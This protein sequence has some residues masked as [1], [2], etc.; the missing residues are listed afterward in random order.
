MKIDY[1]EITKFTTPVRPAHK[2]NEIWEIKIDGRIYWCERPL[3]KWSKLDQSMYLETHKKEGKLLFGKEIDVFFDQNGR[4]WYEKELTSKYLLN[5]FTNN[6]IK[7]I[8]I[9]SR[10]HANMKKIISTMN[11]VHQSI[12]S[13]DVSI[14][15]SNLTK[16]KQC[17]DMFYD[18][19]GSVFMLFDDIVY[20]FRDVLHSFLEKK[21]ANSYFCE[22]LQAEI[23]KEALKLGYAEEFNSKSRS[24]T[25]GKTE[26]VVF[27]KNPIFIY[28][29]EK[30]LEVFAKAASLPDDEFFALRLIMPIGMQINEEAQYVES[31]ILTA[32]FRV[33]INNVAKVLKIKDVEN[34]EYNEI[35]SRLSR[36]KPDLTLFA[37][38]LAIT[39]G[40]MDL[41]T[42]EPMTHCIFHPLYTK[43]WLK[44]IDELMDKSKNIPFQEL[45]KAFNGLSNLRAEITFLFLDL[46]AAKLDKEERLRY[47]NYFHE[48]IKNKAK[49]DTYGFKSNIMHSKQEIDEILSRKF[50]K[51]DAKQAPLLGKLYSA[52][53][54]LTNGLYTDFY[55]D[56]SLE[57]FGPYKIGRDRIL[58][59]KHFA[60][61]R[62]RLLWPE[63]KS[64]CKSFT[65]YQVFEGIKYRCDA[66]SCHG[67]YEGDPVKA[68]KQFRVEVNWKEVNTKEVSQLYEQLSTLSS[69]QWKVM[70][71]L[72]FEELKQ[73]GLEIRCYTMKDLFDFVGIDWKPSAEMKEA[74]K[75]KEWALDFWKPPKEEQYEYWK[76]VLDPTVE[77]F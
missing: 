4:E 64:P 57:S 35:I 3:Y 25:Y 22:F 12:Y 47:A 6:P 15:L 60:D 37:D 72:S 74:V 1:D 62:P 8:E 40:N 13:T 28:S 73:K 71:S 9:M 53:Y 32:H 42:F 58:V 48:I 70:M 24:S 29:S 23:T 26:P 5:F 51:A 7:Y 30:D 76:N 19:Q 67:M 52:G 59:I 56:Y 54:H 46:K 27:Y 20:R 31:R 44:K 21:E 65:I 33:L 36:I 39:T 49:A 77:F 55:C 69:E 41:S 45:A 14:M 34:V 11:E 43:E 38:S 68:L 75:G 10:R 17:F 2:N 18:T 16:I 66:I 50:Q 61:L 63:L